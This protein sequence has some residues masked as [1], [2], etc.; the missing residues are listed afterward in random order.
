MLFRV[1][2]GIFSKSLRR[3]ARSPALLGKARENISIY[4]GQHHR[5]VRR[6]IEK[7]AEPLDEQKGELRP[8]PFET[9][10]QRIAKA[11]PRR[12]GGIPEGAW[13][14]VRDHWS[15]RSNVF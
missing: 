11:P 4:C 6:Y 10:P 3:I 7:A 13:G 9:D 15:G 1:H 5:V 2:V 12:R 14:R 8:L